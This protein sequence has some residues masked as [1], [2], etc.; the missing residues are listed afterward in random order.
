M[1][2]D[3]NGNT[4]EIKSTDGQESHV[5]ES[6]QENGSKKSILPVL[7]TIAVVLSLSLLGY[8]AWKRQNQPNPGIDRRITRH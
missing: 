2:N 1:E 5:N 6:E 3:K 7:L 8:F 4:E